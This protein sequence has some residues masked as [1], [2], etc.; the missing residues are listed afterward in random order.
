MKYKIKTFILHK[1]ILNSS[2]T[3]KTLFD[4]SCTGRFLKRWQD[5]Y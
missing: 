2:F 1:V 4:I 5:F 3:I